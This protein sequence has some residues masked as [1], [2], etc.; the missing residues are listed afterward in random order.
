M[1]YA[2]THILIP[3]LIVAIY[4]DF[5]A[6]N[7]FPLHYVLF[8]GLGGVLPDIDIPISFLVSLVGGGNVWLHGAITHSLFFPL[9]FLVLFLVLKPI[10]LKA[11]VCNIGRHN[12]KLSYL[13]LAIGF[14]VLIHLGLDSIF[15]GETLWLYPFLGTDFGLNVIENF[16][17]RWETVMATLD[18][19][20]L[21]VWIL[22]LEIKHRISD[23]I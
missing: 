11:R 23:F 19:I 15:G 7:K 22:Y 1:P 3:I 10:G 4:R 2:V 20:L 5:F 16:G 17:Y 21:V 14:G 12:L 9:A 13:F 6:K 18:G 8:A